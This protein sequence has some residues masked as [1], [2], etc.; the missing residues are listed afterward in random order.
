MNIE[1]RK[2]SFIQEFL[3]LQNEDIINSLEQILKKGKLQSYHENLKPMSVEQLNS[4][5]DQ[6]MDDSKNGRMTKA[7]E[8]KAKY[9]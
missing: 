6:A 5:I 1:A 8:L 3:K 7:S 9:K 2:I 4:E